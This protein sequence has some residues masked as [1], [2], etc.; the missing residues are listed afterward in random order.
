MCADCLMIA[1]VTKI[2]PRQTSFDSII[3][4]GERPKG[5]PRNQ[6]PFAKLEDTPLLPPP[7]KIKTKL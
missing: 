6:Y 3:P 2:S 7:K 1:S 4:A 5:V